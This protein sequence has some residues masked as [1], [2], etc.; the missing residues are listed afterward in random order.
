T[1]QSG[2]K[3][4]IKLKLPDKKKNELENDPKSKQTKISSRS[5]KNN[6]P[7]DV[8]HSDH[9]RRKKRTKSDSKREH[10]INHRLDNI[11]ESSD[12]EEDD[13]SSGNDTDEMIS[14]ASRQLAY[15]K[16]KIY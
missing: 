10:R 8:G 12:E 3:L 5:N 9:Y 15:L 13:E 4:M 2:L 7:E 16:R 6:N 1:T 11:N 14:K